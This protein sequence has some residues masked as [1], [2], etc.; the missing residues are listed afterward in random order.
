MILGQRGPLRQSVGGSVMSHF[1][2][3]PG[4]SSASH[5]LDWLPAETLMFI[6]ES[7]DG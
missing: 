6:L 3:F 2:L 1:G 5:K 4:S 7:W